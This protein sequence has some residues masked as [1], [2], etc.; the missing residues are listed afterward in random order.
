MDQLRAGWQ[1]LFPSAIFTTAAFIAL[2]WLLFG[3]LFLMFGMDKAMQKPEMLRQRV[4]KVAIPGGQ[5]ARE[6]AS[7]WHFVSDVVIVYLLL[8]FGLLRA[9]PGTF[10]NALLTF[11]VFYVW[12]ETYYYFIH[13]AMHHF[14]LLIPI[15][16]NHHLSVVC[17]PSSASAMSAIEKWILSSLV[18]IGIPAALSWVLPISMPG[19]TAY[20]VFNYFITLG[21]HSNTE[22]SPVSLKMAKLGMGSPTTHALHHARFKVNYGF[23]T[24]LFD[25]LFGT[26]SEETD[27]LRR[28]ALAGNGND[29]LKR[30]PRV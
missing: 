3:K 9:A 17:T 28:R 2:G 23:S 30:R 8:R 29:S 7:S 15:H 22:S 10:A 11:G 27:E 18:W 1:A 5:R 14:K 21:G 26:Y 20:F 24:T 19:V 25:R 4:F 12:V 16:R 6:L 13:R